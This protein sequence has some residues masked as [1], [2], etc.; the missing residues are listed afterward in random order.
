[1]VLQARRGG[2][3]EREAG[4]GGGEVCCGARGGKMVTMAL[5]GARF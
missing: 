4:V 3:P 1:M 5:R 2:E